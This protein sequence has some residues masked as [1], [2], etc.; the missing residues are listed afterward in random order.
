MSGSRALSASTRSAPRL[1]ALL[2][3]VRRM[4]TLRRQRAGLRHLDA[5]LLADIG[6]SRQEAEAEAERPFWDVPAGW[7]R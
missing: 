6:V 1:G 5:H 4:L 3:T 7:Q 2:A